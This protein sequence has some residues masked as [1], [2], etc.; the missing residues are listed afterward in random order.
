MNI[1]RLYI[2]IDDQI[3]AESREE[4]WKIAKEKVIGGFYGP[5]QANL[6]FIEKVPEQG[7][8][9]TAES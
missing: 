7:V 5:T 4:A 1:Y 2:D 8:E 6:E 9:V 3:K